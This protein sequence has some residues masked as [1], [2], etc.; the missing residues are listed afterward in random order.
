MMRGPRAMTAAEVAAKVARECR[1]AGTRAPCISC[2]GRGHVV[3]RWIEGRAGDGVW[4]TVRGC[5]V[6]G[7][8]G[9]PSEFRAENGAALDAYAGRAG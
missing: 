8:D 5:G 6:Y 3:E 4:K 1:L 2:K 7:M 9:D